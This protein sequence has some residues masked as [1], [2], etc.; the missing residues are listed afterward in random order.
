MVG[1]DRIANLRAHFEQMDDRHLT[2]NQ[3]F[4]RL[5]PVVSELMVGAA[6]RCKPLI[7]RAA[8]KDRLLQGDVDLL[9][10]DHLMGSSRRNV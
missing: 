1:G 4:R 5:G 8:I 9:D 2:I 3:I 10:R 6:L 7:T